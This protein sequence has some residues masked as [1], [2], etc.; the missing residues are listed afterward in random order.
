MVSVKTPSCSAELKKNNAVY[1]LAVISQ[2]IT[3][4]VCL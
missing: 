1:S 4:V 2:A 3:G